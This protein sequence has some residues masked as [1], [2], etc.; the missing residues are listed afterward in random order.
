MRLENLMK[1]ARALNVST[2]YLLTGNIIEK[3]QLLL[4][5]KIRNLTA[6]QFRTIES[7]V[8]KCISLNEQTESR[9]RLKVGL[10]PAFFF[11]I[12]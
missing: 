1:I 3:D 8:D 11:Q 2:D 5:D 9:K 10:V 12:A 7:I 6:A 4:S